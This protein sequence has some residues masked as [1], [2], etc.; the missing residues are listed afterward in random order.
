LITPS[1]SVVPNPDRF[2]V[3]RLSTFNEMHDAQI[4]DLLTRVSSIETSI[5]WG[6]GLFAGITV[7]IVLLG[8]FLKAFWRPILRMLVQEASTGSATSTSTPA[9]PAT[10]ATGSGS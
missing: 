7:V 10:S 5:N 3:G 1:P 4:K 8:V 9:P 2:D 6:R